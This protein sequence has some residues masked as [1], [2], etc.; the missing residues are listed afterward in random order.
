LDHPSSQKQKRDELALGQTNYI[1]HIVDKNHKKD[2]S[3]MGLSDNMN[4]SKEHR[5]HKSSAKENHKQHQFNANTSKHER[6]HKDLCDSHKNNLVSNK[7]KKNLTEEKVGKDLV[8]NLDAGHAQN[9]NFKKNKP[10]EE[11]FNKN[12]RSM[13]EKPC[14]KDLGNT[15]DHPIGLKKPPTSKLTDPDAHHPLTHPQEI[16]LDREKINR[17]LA[18]QKSKESQKNLT[19]A[20]GPPINEHPTT[21]QEISGQRKY[22][23]AEEKPKQ[24]Q[25]SESRKPYY[26]QSNNNANGHES[27]VNIKS[28]SVSES[29]QEVGSEY[30]IDD[31]EDISDISGKIK[32]VDGAAMY[33]QKI[34]RGYNTRKRLYSELNEYYNQVDLEEYYSEQEKFNH[35]VANGVRQETYSSNNKDFLKNGDKGPNG[36]RASEKR[37]S[38][39]GKGPVKKD[40]EQFESSK[41]G[42]DDGKSKSDMGNSGKDVPVK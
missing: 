12:N 17:N 8:Q 34:W 1:A 10:K 4:S 28:P 2:K 13:K 30:L 14:H 36:S 35:G 18:N 19:D 23:E 38:E 15:Q 21:K 40:A 37:E 22:S 29:Q 9:L 25:K 42:F 20:K 33:I 24:L 39:F 31:L 16:S 27:S 6:S 5:E 3:N 41:K 7:S 11:N 32:I 26:Y